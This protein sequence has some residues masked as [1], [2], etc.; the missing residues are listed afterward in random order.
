[1]PVALIALVLA[2]VAPDY[3]GVYAKG[4]P[5]AQFLDEATQLEKEWQE[6]YE[7]AAIEDASLARAK[8]LQGSWRLLVVAEDWCHDS[9]G[10]VPY[11]AKLADAAPDTI[12]LRIV[13][14]VDGQ[15]VM[16]AHKT[17]DGRAATPTIVVL[18]A[19][20]EIMGT[21]AER[22]T[23]LWEYSKEHSGRG[24]RRQWYTD[25]QGRHAVAEILDLIEK[26]GQ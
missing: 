4:I 2:L 12:Q 9:L 22:P 23:A 7:K 3:T 6:N 1:M 24:E 10:T 15:T 5:F 20:G 16:D 14:T 18:D 17:P 21:I 19:A 26:S 13:R 8:A 11:L 25:D